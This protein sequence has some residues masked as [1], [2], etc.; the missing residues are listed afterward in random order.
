MALLLGRVYSKQAA[1]V[2]GLW[3]PVHRHC[4]PNIS[5]HP[6]R[7]RVSLA[8]AKPTYFLLTLAPR[9]LVEAIISLTL[10]LVTHL[11][12]NNVPKEMPSVA[13]EL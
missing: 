10:V 3:R 5:H 9:L 7:D 4:N 8:S 12:A 1:N 2:A 11:G 6:S 13:L